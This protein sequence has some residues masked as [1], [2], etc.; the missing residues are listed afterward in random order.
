[1][2][3][4]ENIVRLAEPAQGDGMGWSR[5]E[6]SDSRT[7]SPPYQDNLDIAGCF[8]RLASFDHQAFDRLHRYETALW[9]QAG[10]VLFTLNTLQGRARLPKHL[11]KQSAYRATW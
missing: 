8:L 11:A 1:M 6:G 3:R 5:N 4:R 10:Q 9:R 2:Q 7:S